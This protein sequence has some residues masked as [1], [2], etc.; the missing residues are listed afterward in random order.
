M[1]DFTS[2]M[3]GAAN[4][5]GR[6]QDALQER[7]RQMQTL[8]DHSPDQIFRVDGNHR[9]V[10]VNR[11][12]AEVTGI[13][14]DQW[15]GHTHHEV[16]MP[17][18]LCALWD[19]FF[20]EVFEAGRARE[21]EYVYAGREGTRHYLGRLVP[22]HDEDGE[23]KS[24]LGI[25]RD[26]TERKLAEEQLVEGEQRY[27]ALVEDMNAIVWE[28]DL[29]GERYSFVSRRAELFLGYPI[30][31]WTDRR[32]W[33]DHIHPE[34][35]QR[36]ITYCDARIQQGRDHAIEYRMQAANGSVVWVHD[37]VRVIKDEFGRPRRLRGLMVDVTERKRNE[38]LLAERQS[39]L[40]LQNTVTMSISEG[41]TVEAIVDLTDRSA[42]SRLSR[43][44]LRDRL[45]RP[46]VGH[47]F[48]QSRIDAERSRLQPGSD[49]TGSRVLGRAASATATCRTGRSK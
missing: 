3:P 32:F 37:L 2:D 4:D 39:R 31:Q 11:R 6:I 42:F 10:L 24:L 25:T 13:P 15:I 36:C 27:R 8:A 18:A 43:Q 5:E 19:Q 21:Y 22:E 46:A 35:R 17:Q 34:D 44:F 47:P 41:T 23:V 28:L 16:G 7:T 33:I 14:E 29:A 9:Y 1:T 38:R 49:E 12:L 20:T 30:S 26:V 48:H 40:E 45:G